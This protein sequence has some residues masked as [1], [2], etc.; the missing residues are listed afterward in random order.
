MAAS[1]PGSLP[2]YAER[3]AWLEATDTEPQA[4]RRGR[5][6][7]VRAWAAFWP[8]ALAIVI[9]LAIWQLIHVSGW[10][11]AIFPGPGATLANLWDQAHTGL[12]WHAITTTAGRA[13]IGFGLAVVV[14]PN[15]M[16]ANGNQAIDGMVCSPVI[17]EP[18][19]ARS[20][21][22]LDTSAPITAPIST[23]S[24]NPTTARL[25]VVAMACHSRPVCS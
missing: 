11:K 9:V 2:T 14:M 21:A 20:G 5:G 16:I 7:A 24:P 3:L 23:A 22:I 18:T 25:A 15:K 1:N 4:G 10:K 17:R 13:V 12:L 19:A 8:K 6:L